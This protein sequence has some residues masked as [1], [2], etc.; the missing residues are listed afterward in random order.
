MEWIWN[1]VS[2][3]MILDVGTKFESRQSF[4]PGSA[5]LPLQWYAIFRWRYSKLGG[6]SS[7]FGSSKFELFVPGVVRGTL[8]IS[9]KAGGQ[10]STNDH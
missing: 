4:K 5:Q 7:N 1:C 3:R 8:N 9:V 10:I 6:K 2:V